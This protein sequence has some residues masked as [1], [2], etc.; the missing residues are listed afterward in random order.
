M[1]LCTPVKL[2]RH[3]VTIKFPHWQLRTA[4]QVA[5]R[6]QIRRHGQVPFDSG[7]KL[8][9]RQNGRTRDTCCGGFRFVRWEAASPIP[10]EEWRMDERGNNLITN[11]IFG[12]VTTL[13]GELSLP[14]HQRRVCWPADRCPSTSLTVTARSNTLWVWFY[15]QPL[16]SLHPPG[17]KISD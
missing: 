7:C 2:K 15:T 6:T 4:G 12:D 11:G 10:T 9:H 16:T 3:K 14:E 17:L 1:F 8:C 13:H 5:L